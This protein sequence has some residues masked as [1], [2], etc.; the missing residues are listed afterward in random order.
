MT[1]AERRARRERIVAHM[2]RRIVDTWTL[3]TWLTSM[4]P[5][6]RDAWI[7]M[8]AKKMADNP[9][10]CSGLCCGNARKHYGA[11]VSELRRASRG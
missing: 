3:S 9:Q 4:T 2:R 7:D 8:T 1:R 6:E 5:D 11:P 10:R